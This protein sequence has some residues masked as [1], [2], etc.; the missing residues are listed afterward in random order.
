M[1]PR[2]APHSNAAKIYLD[3][4]LSRDGQLAWS[5]AT[6]LTS[7]RSDVPN[8][9]IPEVFVPKPGVNYL[10]DYKEPFVVLRDEVVT[11]VNSALSR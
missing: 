4:L 8:D 7:R 5:K 3:Y 10:A 2:N 9:H 6:G 1:V 11:F